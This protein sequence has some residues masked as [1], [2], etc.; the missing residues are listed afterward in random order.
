MPS[1]V[2]LRQSHTPPSFF[3]AARKSLRHGQLLDGRNEKIAECEAMSQGDFGNNAFERAAKFLTDTLERDHE[4]VALV[5]EVDA[6][7]L[8]PMANHGWSSLVAM[9]ILAFPEVRWVF[10][11]IHGLPSRKDSEAAEGETDNQR[12]EREEL[13]KQR[14]D[15]RKMWQAVHDSCG[16]HTLLAPRGTSLFDG[17]GLRQRVRGW[18][19]AEHDSGQARGSAVDRNF[20]PIP[21]RPKLAV[22]LDDE[23][24]YSHFLAFMA[25]ARGFRV[26]A[27]SSWSEA[28]A[29]LGE[30]GALFKDGGQGKP[31]EVSKHFLLSIEDWY[32]NFPDQSTRGMS[33]LAQ[34][35]EHLPG[36][37]LT[38][39]RHRR[40]VTVGHEQSSDG[41]RERNRYLADL[42]LMEKAQCGR[43]VRKAEQVVF[44]DCGMRS[45]TSTVGGIPGGW[46][47]DTTGHHGSIRWI[48]PRI[49]TA[50]ARPE[51]W[52]GSPSTF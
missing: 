9:L 43:V 3:E 18:M 12:K 31:P 20:Q 26:H 25:Y 8:N 32:L 7:R 45:R 24:D 33:D 28:S 39:P 27:I 44:L 49:T 16:V 51:N 40:F 21:C 35:Q 48:P 5:D 38:T 6:T 46:H 19:Q 15:E 13:I 4:V 29:L 10:Q 2:I 37:S 36:L 22:V 14:D 11:V 47:R 23:S 42:R 34:R 52:S 30:D 17:Y 50:T 1:Y 41:T